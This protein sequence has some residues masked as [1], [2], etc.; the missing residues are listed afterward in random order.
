VVDEKVEVGCLRLPFAVASVDCVVRCVLLWDVGE[1][2]QSG[3]SLVFHCV[4]K[5][6]W[7]FTGFY[8][9]YTVSFTLRF[10]V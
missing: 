3:F 10:T 7:V 8:S 4:F 1:I 2:W 5:M 9:F 6:T